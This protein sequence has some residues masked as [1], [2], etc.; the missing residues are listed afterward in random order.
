M[1]LG[2]TKRRLWGPGWR[3]FFAMIF[4]GM[5]F[6]RIVSDTSFDVSPRPFIATAAIAV[7]FWIA[8]FIGLWRSRARIL[9]VTTPRRRTRRW[10][11]PPPAAL[12]APSC[13]AAPEGRRRSSPTVGRVL[14]DFVHDARAALGDTL[15]SIV[16]F[17]SAENGSVHVG[18]QRRRRLVGVRPD[19]HRAA[20]P[21]LERAMGQSASKSSGCW[22]SRWPSPRLSRWFGDIVRRHRVLHGPDR[23]RH[24][25]S[26]ARPPSR[27]SGRCSSISSC[28]FRASYATDGGREDRLALRIAD[29]AGP[30]RV[31]AAEILELEGGPAAPARRPRPR[32]RGL[33]RTRSRRGAGGNQRGSRDAT[34]GGRPGGDLLL[35][36][37]ELASFLHKRAAL[38]S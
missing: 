10:Q 36:V 24:S 18:R 30:L 4:S 17:G 28:G 6:G 15:Q 25:P 22:N 20:A 35:R 37:I 19:W 5:A 34:P 33:D 26:P 3:L 27:V 32:G 14:N 8:F 38:L 13:R 7:A 12:P 29:A 21:A 2:L 16:L 9:V 23:S 1:A 31:S 11:K